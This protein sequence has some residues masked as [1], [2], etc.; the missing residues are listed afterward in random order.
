MP[1]LSERESLTRFL[2]LF[3]YTFE[4][5]MKFVEGPDQIFKRSFYCISKYTLQSN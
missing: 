4:M 3:F 2:V 5:E 1:I